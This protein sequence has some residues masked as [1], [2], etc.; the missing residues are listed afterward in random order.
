MPLQWPK[1]ETAEVDELLLGNYAPDERLPLHCRLLV[2]LKEL[3]DQLD[4]L[5][6][7]FACGFDQAMK[8]VETHAQEDE[9]C[10]RYQLCFS[11]LT[12]SPRWRHNQ[13]RSCA[14][15]SASARDGL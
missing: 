8:E 2:R 11:R 10:R 15:S 1:V 6:S 14:S 5:V 4:D 13:R 9:V 7:V 12:L 3:K